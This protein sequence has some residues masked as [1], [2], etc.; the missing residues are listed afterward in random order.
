MIVMPD[1]KDSTVTYTE[2]SSP[3]E[4]L[5][6]IGSPGVDGLPMMQEDPYAYVEAALQALPSPDYVPG[7]EHPPS[8]VY[9]PY[10]MGYKDTGIGWLMPCWRLPAIRCAPA[11]YYAILMESEDRLSSEAWVQSMDASDTARFEVRALRTTVLAQ[12]TEI[13]DLRDARERRQF[14]PHRDTARDLAHPDVPEEAGSRVVNKMAP[15]RTTRSTPTTTTTPTTSVTDGQLKKLIAQGVAD[16][17]AERE[18]TRSIN[19]E[20]IHD[21][22]IVVELTQ[23]FERME[24][25]FRI[26]NCTMENKIKFATCTLLGSAL[27]WWNSHVRT[28]GHDVAYAMLMQYY[29]LSDWRRRHE[30]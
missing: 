9:V 8:P 13:E 4:D 23:W 7:L 17:L 26:S 28:F 24:I 5:S 19:G 20:D 12:Q 1:L 22:G 6:D 2:V 16:V 25:M 18:A 14:T 10:V 29:V 11:T 21:S 27:T 30:F 3:F 15:K